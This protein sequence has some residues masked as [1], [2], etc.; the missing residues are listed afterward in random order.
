MHLIVIGLYIY[1]LFVC[2]NQG[3]TAV[4]ENCLSP[5]DIL[6]ATLLRLS[7]FDFH[8]TPTHPPLPLQITVSIIHSLL[9]SLP[10]YSINDMSL[11]A[12]LPE[13]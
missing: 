5:K 3:G 1:S 8:N 7:S 13:M 4:E 6:K 9:P 2:N 10:D 12:I 11:K